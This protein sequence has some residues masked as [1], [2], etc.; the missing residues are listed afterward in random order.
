[1]VFGE[2]FFELWKGFLDIDEEMR[3]LEQSQE[4][5]RLKKFCSGVELG[6]IET[7]PSK[8]KIPSSGSSSG[9]HVKGPVAKNGSPEDSRLPSRHSWRPMLIKCADCHIVTSIEAAVAYSRS[10]DLGI[11]FAYKR[12]LVSQAIQG[13][14]YLLF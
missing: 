9:E 7:W 8:P 13:L 11:K 5:P 3:I 14:V 10:V 1:M 4:L 6:R 12:V 2:E